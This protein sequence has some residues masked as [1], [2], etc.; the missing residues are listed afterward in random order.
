MAGVT[1][2]GFE[3]PTVLELKK[4]FEDDQRA[5]ISASLDLSTDTVIGQINGIFA[6][7]LGIAWEAIETVYHGFDPDAAEDFL[8]IALCKLT[9]TPQ[10]PA[11]QSEVDCVV[12]LDGGA[13]LLAGDSFGS[14]NGRPDVRWTPKADYTAPSDGMHTVRFVAENT[15]PVVG[16]TGTITVI[17]TPVVGWNS[18]TNPGDA[19]LGR[20]IDSD[21]TLRTRREQQLT[22]AGSSTVD[23]IAA[24]LEALEDMETVTMFENVT[25]LPDGN[26]LPPHS[27]EAVVFDNGA[28]GNNLIAQ[29]IWNTRPAGI[30]PFGTLSGSAVD[31]ENVIRSVPFSRSAEQTV[32]L[33][34]T[35]ATGASYV[36]DSAF[37]TAIVTKCNAIFGTTDDV[38]AARVGALPFELGLGVTDQSPVKLGLAPSP[39]G[40]SNIPIGARQIARFDTARIVIV[41][42]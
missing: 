33:T 6:R 34:F 38:I 4:Q 40:T 31:A 3:R 20:V 24:D 9:G 16:A 25:D 7:H 26:G 1:A 14:I 27:F 2:T 23:A 37:K 11:S 19:T 10:R 30:E 22:R 35:M 36:G 18:I 29:T 41:A 21:A 39:A 8:L 15:G 32:Y 17:A 5:E 12:D 13:T 28:I 42:L